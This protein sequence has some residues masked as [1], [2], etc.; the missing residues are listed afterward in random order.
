MSNN[1]LFIRVLRKED[2]LDL[3][4]ELVNI[5]TN[6]YPLRL[7]RRNADEPVLLIVHFPAQHIVEEIFSEA[8]PSVSP[9]KAML[10]GP[11]RLVFELPEDENNWPLT[12]ETLLNWKNYKPVVPKLP[13][14]DPSKPFT[15]HFP[16]IFEGKTTLEIPT[17]LY[18]SPEESGV[19]YH[20]I[21]PEGQDGRFVLWHTE[22]GEKQK[23]NEN[24]FREGGTTNL[25]TAS[26]HH[27][28]FNSAPTQKQ[29]NEIVKLT[30]DYSMPKPPSGISKE[31]WQNKLNELRIPNPYIPSPINLRRLI[32]ST[33]GAW[34]NLEGVWNYPTVFDKTLGYETLS[35]EG[36]QQ[37][38][39]QGE[40]NLLKQQKRPFYVI[41]GMPY[42]L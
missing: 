23:E 30:T 29:L 17:G 9:I 15:P 7:V 40:T 11:S 14:P 38:I 19:W 24:T 3:I 12:M 32:L 28:P 13:N 4:F 10:S 33:A 22:L 1:N 8:E 27:I 39:T 18:L 6:G 20:L 5:H 35:L 16:E 42:R 25:I 37:I 2:F 21:H 36:W 31:A 26:N 34:S 41:Q